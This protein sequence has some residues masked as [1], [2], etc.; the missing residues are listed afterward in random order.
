MLRS[1]GYLLD[2]NGFAVST[3]TVSDGEIR[4]CSCFLCSGRDAYGAPRFHRMAAYTRCD[5][6]A[7]PL[8]PLQRARASPKC[9][10]ANR[11]PSVIEP[12][13]GMPKRKLEKG[14]QRLAPQNL[15]FG[16]EILKI[17]R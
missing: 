16:P 6:P 9:R 14:E 10:S 5:H 2:A 11:S 13:C 17:R 4:D 8:P 3:T 15:G 7:S 12:V 1:I